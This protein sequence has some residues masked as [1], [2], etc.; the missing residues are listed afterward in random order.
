MSPRGAD[1]PDRQPSVYRYELPAGFRVWAGRTDR[2]NDELSLRVAGPNDYW[3]HLRG[4]PGSHVVLFA[5]GREPDRESIK[6]A[7]AIAA[8]HSKARNA[9]TVSVDCTQAKHLSKPRGA[10]PGT[11]RLKRSEVIKVR[12]G[13]PVPGGGPPT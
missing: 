11:V 4:Q 1:R 13:L 10:K 5:E 2:D 12:P 6:Q 7:A 3:F 9:G 8:Y